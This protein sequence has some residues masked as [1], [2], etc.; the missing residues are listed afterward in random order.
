MRYRYVN[1]VVLMTGLLAAPVAMAQDDP[2]DL[3]LWQM[4]THENTPAGYDIY[5]QVFPNGKFAALARIRSQQVAQPDP[6]PIPMPTPEPMPAPAPD[7]DAAPQFS[8]TPP[9]VHVGQRFT[10]DCSTLPSGGRFDT[11]IAVPAGSPP[12]QAQGMTQGIQME[13]LANCQA[14]NNNGTF[15]LGPL[16]PGRWEFRWMTS[17]YNLDNR[18]EM[19]AK[20]DV[21]VR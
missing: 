21:V 3:G 19:K 12:N 14:G 13:Y 1:A 20:V 18:S 15:L 9:V 8:V 11:I 7:A 10:V 4:A 17:L 16:P 5:L 2:A 6:A